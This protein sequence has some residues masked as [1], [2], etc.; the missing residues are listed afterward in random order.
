MSDTLRKSRL[1]LRA[2]ILEPRE[3]MAS[4]VSV[5][6]AA[7]SSQPLIAETQ[8]VSLRFDNAGSSVGFGPYIDVVLPTSSPDGGAGGVHY[9]PGSSSMLDTPLRETILTFD[10]NGKAT[11]PLARD[12]SGNPRVLVGTPGNQL[13]VLELPFGS[14]VA[15]QPAVQVDMQIAIDA[16]A[17]LGLSLPIIAAGGFRF[18]NDSLDN[19]TKDPSIRGAEAELKITPGIVNTRII[20]VGPENETATGKS[21]ERAYRVDVDVATG[22]DISN[23]VL[24]HHLDNNQAYLGA[25]DWVGL[26]KDLS[27]ATQ[28]VVG[29]PSTQSD[30]VMNLA[31]A[32][33]VA[34]VDGSYLI[35]FYIPELNASALP[36]IDTLLAKNASSVFTVQASGDWDKPAILVNETN[37]KIKFNTDQATHV[38]QD[39]V[40]ASQQSVRIVDD[41]NAKSLN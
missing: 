11:H 5:S 33:G 9:V 21:F 16:S 29:A 34:G 28:P 39:K 30:I 24:S 19:P 6:W 7:L 12:S 10:A 3:M 13:V 40:I 23:L 22:A 26:G 2:E 27:I 14:Y 38:L 4:D 8:H 35:R 20:Y 32:K 37:T 18:G 31:K 15:E 41:V 17:E 1:N 25:T 36:I